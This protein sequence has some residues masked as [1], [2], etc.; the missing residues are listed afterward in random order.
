MFVSVVNVCPYASSSVFKCRSRYLKVQ[1]ILF[2]ALRAFRRAGFR[3]KLFLYWDSFP[4]FSPQVEFREEVTSQ[5]QV[6]GPFCM[7][8]GNLLVTFFLLFGALV[9]KWDPGP[10]S[11]EKGTPKTKQT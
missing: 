6:S 8:F 1:P 11:L 7:T 10:K 3:D 5:L 4:L 9:A 2:K